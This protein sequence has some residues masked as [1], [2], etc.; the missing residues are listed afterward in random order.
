MCHKMC[1]GLMV[2]ALSLLMVVPASAA[3]KIVLHGASQ[4]DD[5]HAFNRTMLKF[6]ELVET[7]L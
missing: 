3:D 6:Q 4:F 1:K 2:L 7:V 5:D